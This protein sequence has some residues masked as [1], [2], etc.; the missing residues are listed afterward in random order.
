MKNARKR[1]RKQKDCIFF[2]RANFTSRI[3]FPA[4]CKRFKMLENLLPVRQ[5]FT[6]MDCLRN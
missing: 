4:V 2:F 3:F 5:I 1:A 6:H